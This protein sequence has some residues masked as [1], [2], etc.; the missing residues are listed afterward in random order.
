MKLAIMQPYFFPYLGY[1][2]LIAAVDKFL[3]YDQTDCIKRGWLDR[4][5][6]REP[7]HGTAFFRI[8]VKGKNLGNRISEM[9]IDYSQMWQRKLCDQIRHNYRRALFFDEIYPF[10]VRE[11]GEKHRSLSDFNWATI[12]AVSG[13]LGIKTEIARCD[14]TARKI[15][16]L[17]RCTDNTGDIKLQRIVALC[18]SESMLEYVNPIGGRAIYDRDA[19]LEHGISLRF[20]QMDADDEELSS[21]IRTPYFSIIDTLFQSGAHGTAKLLDMYRLI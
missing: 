21:V 19:F 12:K 15:E 4:N 18:R 3:V 6:M 9:E 7:K 16:S 20:I 8:P 1:F 5:V 2:Q 13:L 17:V 10:L 14:E 11:I